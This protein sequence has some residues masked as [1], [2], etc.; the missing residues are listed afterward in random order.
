MASGPGVD[1]IERDIAD[2]L[3]EFQPPFAVSL[4]RHECDGR[5]P[6]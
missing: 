1:A 3:F 6:D 2:G 4:G 5:L